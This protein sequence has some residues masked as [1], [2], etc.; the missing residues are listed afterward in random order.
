MVLK[1]LGSYVVK[2]QSSTINHFHKPLEQKEIGAFVRST[3]MPT[4]Y[5][6][7]I[8]YYTQRP[9]EYLVIYYAIVAKALHQH[10]VAGPHARVGVR[11]DGEMHPILFA[12][13]HGVCHNYTQ[14]KWRLVRRTS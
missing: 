7:L 11:G 13:Y 14:S 4:K 6:A 9:S 2:V 5:N 1:G 8:P 10:A 12:P 3:Y